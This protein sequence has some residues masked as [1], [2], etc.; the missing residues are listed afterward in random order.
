METEKLLVPIN[1]GG[2]TENYSWTQSAYDLCV[3]IP[4]PENTLKKDIVIQIKT[5]K[6]L[7]KIKDVII[8]EG[9][10]FADILNDSSMWYISKNNIEIELDKLKKHDWW[11]CVIIGHPE[12]DTTK[13]RPDSEHITDLDSETRATIDKMLYDQQMKEKSST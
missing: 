2:I 5:N 6:L 11:K 7:V 4:L 12:I 3:I 10:L 13:V 8:V 1:N 9:D